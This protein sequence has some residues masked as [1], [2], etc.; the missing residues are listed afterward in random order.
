VDSY[1]LFFETRSLVFEFRS[2]SKLLQSRS[3]DLHLISPPQ[4]FCGSG[5]GVGIYG[6]DVA[7]FRCI[8]VALFSV[9][10]TSSK[11]IHIPSLCSTMFRTL[12]LCHSFT[13][14]ISGAAIAP[15]VNKRDASPKPIWEPQAGA[16][17]QIILDSNFRRSRQSDVVPSDADIFD[18]DLFD[19]SPEL[20]RK[21]HNRGKKVICYMNAGSSETWRSDYDSIKAADKGDVMK[22]W[23]R[24]QWLDIRSPDVFEVMKKRIQMASTKGCDAI[25]PDNV[26]QCH[27]LKMCRPSKTN[28]DRRI[29]R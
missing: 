19:T 5:I 21:L 11:Q 25:D 1:L 10:A 15:Y 9:F 7:Y 20:I 8:S 29:W 2:R 24:E 6:V 4:A 28:F 22:E 14:L 23:R 27:F 13:T 12:L 3:G 17:F 26:G 18:L 16:K